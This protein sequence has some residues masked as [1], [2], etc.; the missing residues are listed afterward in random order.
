MARIFTNRKSGFIQ[1]S[2]RMR[3][4]TSWVGIA[5]SETTLAPLTPVAF[6]GFGATVLGLRPFTIVR[7]RGVL[8]LV[9]DQT[10]ATES[11]HAAMGFAVVSNDVLAVGVTALPTPM[12]DTESDLFFVYE[13]I[14]AR[15]L[16]ATAVG[17]S[18]S[19]FRE[20]DSKAMRRVEDGQDLSITVESDTAPFAGCTI[21]KGGRLLIKL[22]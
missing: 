4:E 12:S 18:R 15:T 19:F 5:G 3:R 1:R 22:H 11:I 8:G 10:A 16:V 20:F 13:A 21:L 6:T 7:V 14:I 2:G 17:L 9:S